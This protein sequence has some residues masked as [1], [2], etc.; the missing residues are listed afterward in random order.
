MLNPE[1][2]LGNVIAGFMS[3]GGRSGGG[4][5][6]LL[7][8]GG[9]RRS[10]GMGAGGLMALGGVALAAY[11]HYTAQQS[12]A[13]QPSAPHQAPPPLPGGGNFTPPPPP[14]VPIPESDFETSL[15]VRAIR[16]M[17]LV[18]AADGR[19]SE[20]ERMAIEDK[21][22]Q[23]S[24]DEADFIRNEIADPKPVDL[25]ASGVTDENE[26]ETIFG[27]ACFAGKAD[28]AIGSVE[29]ATLKDLAESLGL[30]NDRAI[31]I[32]GSV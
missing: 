14:P 30:E 22:G 1:R 2:M 7:S 20:E 11:E 27:L 15:G 31:D 13:E 26:K 25:I 12:N 10:S 18:S 17:I 32:M 23:L 19:I 3:G 16:A 9:R 8:G 28:G 4:L 21:L 29:T 5:G 24:D 6:S